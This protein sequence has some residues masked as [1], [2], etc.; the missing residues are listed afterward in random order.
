MGK[1]NIYVVSTFYNW[2]LVDYAMRTN[3]NQDLFFGDFFIIVL[4]KEHE[5]T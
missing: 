3:S 1:L 4:W 2:D 5:N